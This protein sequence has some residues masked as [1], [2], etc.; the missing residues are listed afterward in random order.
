MP[1]SKAGNER[2]PVLPIYGWMHKIN[3]IDK[4]IETRQS[5]N[6]KSMQFHLPSLP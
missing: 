3:K 2:T 1:I 5:L 4:E 6:L